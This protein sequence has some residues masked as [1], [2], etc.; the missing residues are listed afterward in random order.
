M[1]FKNIVEQNF[2]IPVK[3]IPLISKKALKFLENL[4]QPDPKKRYSAEEA[5]N[6]DW[7]KSYKSLEVQETDF[8]TIVYNLE[9]FN[10]K[11]KLQEAIYFFYLNIYFDRAEQNKLIKSFNVLD[12]NN[13]GIITKQELKEG[14]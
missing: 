3:K 6:D 13:D 14:L 4:L 2:V 1:L 11:N 12:Q 10:M 8:D 7:I 9:N 5:L